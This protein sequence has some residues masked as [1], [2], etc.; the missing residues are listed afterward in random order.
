MLIKNK[1]AKSRFRFSTAYLLVL[2]SL[3][4][5]QVEK[6]KALFKGL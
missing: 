5:S 3:E 2:M 1:V 6:L 4:K